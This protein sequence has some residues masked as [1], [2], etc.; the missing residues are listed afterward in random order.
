MAA[1][2]VFACLA[3]ASPAHCVGSMQTTTF[4]T[5]VCS[6]LLGS[7]CLEHTLDDVTAPSPVPDAGVP[8]DPTEPSLGNFVR[9][10]NCMTIEDFRSANMVKEWTKLYAENEQYCATCHEN[11]GDGHIVTPIE[12]K[13]FTTLKTNKYYALQYFTYNAVTETFTVTENRVAMTGVSTGAD[14]HRQHPR[15]DPTEALAASKL[16]AALTQAKYTVAKGNCR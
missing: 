7:A 14:P 4:L 13:F 16:F 15:F 6:A 5:M 10:Q 9:W 2:F 12:D 11:G 3:L 8:T 1:R